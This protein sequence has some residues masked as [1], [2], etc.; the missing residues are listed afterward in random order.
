MWTICGAVRTGQ[1]CADWPALC[2]PA[3]AV[4][5]LSSRLLDLRA[6]TFPRLSLDHRCSI[7]PLRPIRSFRFVDLA[8]DPTCVGELAWDQ[9]SSMGWRTSIRDTTERVLTEAD[10]TNARIGGSNVS[11][12]MRRFRRSG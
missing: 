6:R 4:A 7:R 3:G 2:G 5:P 9:L 10:L 12:T 11:G 1:R 8:L